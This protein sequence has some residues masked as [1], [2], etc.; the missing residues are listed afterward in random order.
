MNK[1][2]RDLLE[3]RSGG[4]CENC[5]KKAQDAAHIEPKMAGGRKGFLEK[6]FDDLRNLVA[7]CRSCHDLID[8]KRKQ[9]F[10]GERDHALARFKE[11]SGWDGWAL[12]AIALGIRLR[13]SIR[14]GHG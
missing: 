5:G 13:N 2:T 14:G 7:A 12:E 9:L 3:Q 8:L 4:L 10:P 11:K 1:K 6:F